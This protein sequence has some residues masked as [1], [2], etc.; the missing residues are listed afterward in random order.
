SADGLSNVNM[1][2]LAIKGIIAIRAMAEI[3]RT[4]SEFD[5]SNSYLST[6]SSLAS[7]WQTLAGSSG[8]L[9]STYGASSSWG[10]M[11]NLY[12]D[13]LLGFNLVDNDVSPELPE[14]SSPQPFG[15]PYDSDQG[16]TAQ[17]HWTIFTAG[18][19]TN[20]SIRDSLVSMV[21]VAASNPNN[22]AVF[23]TMYSTSDGS[24]LGG[25]AR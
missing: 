13:K 3:S 14:P 4:V 9:T 10:L 5:D 12:P 20:N 24:N 6:A 2:N 11:Y 1:T 15:L 19:V 17:S 16:N 23:P 25:S 22:F 8:H 7:Q 18:T 21:H